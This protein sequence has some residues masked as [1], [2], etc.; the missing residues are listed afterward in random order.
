MVPLGEEVI[1]KFPTLDRTAGE[2]FFLAF[3]VSN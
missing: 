3:V 1:F 2:V